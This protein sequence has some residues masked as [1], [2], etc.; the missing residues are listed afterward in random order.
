MIKKGVSN[1]RIS[2]LGGGYDF[3]KYFKHTPVTVLAEGIK[4]PV[5]CSVTTDTI[6]W[7][8]PK[9]KKGL[10]TSSAKWIS[11]F[12]AVASTWVE[13]K[14]INQAISLES[15]QK[16]GWQDPIA[17]AY[18][19]FIKIKLFENDW[20]V[21]RLVFDQ[22]FF[23]YRKLYEISTEH[24]IPILEYMEP[25]REHQS[26]MSNYVEQ[27]ITALQQN[28]FEAFGNALKEGWFLKKQWHPDISNEEIDTMCSLADNAGAYGYKVCGAGGQGY[29]L[30]I[31]NP[32][33][34]RQ[35]KALYSSKNL[36][37]PYS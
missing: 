34:H 6:K 15:I 36:A 9:V 23:E 32:D 7:D 16:G 14:R 8:F 5:I 24:E 29:L 10:S 30:V 12:R 2:Y 22:E 31:G 4:L 25:N 19:G 11:F 3:P 13:R 26:L 1:L 27:G 37:I 35:L 17:C 21:K 28:N 18:D 33:C 20:E